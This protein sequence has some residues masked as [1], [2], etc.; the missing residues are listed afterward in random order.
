MTTMSKNVPS[1]FST[2][3]L[4]ISPSRQLHNLHGTEICALN[5]TNLSSTN[6]ISV[7]QRETQYTSTEGMLPDFCSQ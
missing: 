4:E 1:L 2:F 3:G 6:A 7:Q 5:V